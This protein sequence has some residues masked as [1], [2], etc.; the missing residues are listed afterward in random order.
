MRAV[1]AALAAFIAV[2]VVACGTDTSKTEGSQIAVGIAKELASRVA[3]GKKKAAGTPDPEKLAASAKSSFSGPIIV[4][5]MEKTGL[6]TALGEIGR[7]A[8]VRTFVT[9]SEQ[10]IM[11]R[12]GLL[13]GTRGLGNDLMST[14]LGSAAALVGGR[15]GG[16]TQRVW[17]YLDGEGIERPLPMNC[18][19]TRGPA[20]SFTFAGNAHSTVQMD[21]N[22]S[23]QGLS[24]S[25]SYWVTGN[26][27]IALSHQW[28]GPALGHV[29]IQL[30]RN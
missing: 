17:R 26:G 23:G 19:I 12:Q 24:I 16:Q 30:V 8:G 15:T 4:A 29:T 10:A 18:T 11:L 2:G 20:K 21:E 25:N 6:L 27:T 22:C 28:I 5:Q 13:V 3:P 1:R 7:N 14:E 9:P